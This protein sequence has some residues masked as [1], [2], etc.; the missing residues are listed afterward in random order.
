MLALQRSDGI[1]RVSL[2]IRIARDL[3]NMD[4]VHQ[5]QLALAVAP[6]IERNFDAIREA[7][8]KSIRTE[9]RLFELI[10]DNSSPG[11][12]DSKGEP[13]QAR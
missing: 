13:K 6:W 12:F 10:L 8:L 9:R 3:L 7:A 2:S 1:E 11:P 4:S 5:D